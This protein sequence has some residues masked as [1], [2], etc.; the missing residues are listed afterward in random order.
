MYNTNL[1][2]SGLAHSTEFSVKLSSI[3]YYLGLETASQAIMFHTSIP[4][5]SV[6]VTTEVTQQATVRLAC[7]QVSQVQ[8]CTCRL[9]LRWP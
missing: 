3:N 5:D 8:G 7:D 1:S 4:G 9:S 6:R 2:S